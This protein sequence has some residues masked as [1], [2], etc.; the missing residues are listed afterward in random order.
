VRV[1]LTTGVD[2]DHLAQPVPLL[3]RVLQLGVDAARRDDD[4]PHDAG[5]HSLLEQ[6][7]H[8]RLRD[9]Q[10]RRDLR[11]ADALLVIELRDLGEQPQMISRRLP[12]NPRPRPLSRTRRRHAQHASGYRIRKM[13]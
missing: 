12:P 8:P 1:V 7:G 11:L 6:P 5:Q 2:H 4:R 3:D 9:V 13:R 10:L